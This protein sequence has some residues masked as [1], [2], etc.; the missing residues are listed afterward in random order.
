MRTCHWSFPLNLKRTFT[1]VPWNFALTEL[2][3][4]AQRGPAA[5][6]VSHRPTYTSA[7]S[8][9]AISTGNACGVHSSARASAIL[10]GLLLF[11]LQGVHGGRLR[12]LRA[13]GHLHPG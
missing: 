12:A 11:P 10:I 6:R 5:S 7:G 9:A 3:A 8:F 13:D 4:Q 1:A 2:P